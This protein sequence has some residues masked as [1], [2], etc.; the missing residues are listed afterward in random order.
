MDLFDIR[1]LPLRFLFHC[2]H[3]WYCYQNNAL[4]FLLYPALIL[5]SSLFRTFV[6][7]IV[8]DSN[9]SSSFDDTDSY[10]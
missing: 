9:G 2:V 6:S 7:I 1:C 4:Q 10:R 5:L 8:N 3:N